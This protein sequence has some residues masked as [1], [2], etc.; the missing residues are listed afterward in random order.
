MKRTA[1]L[2]MIMLALAYPTLGQKKKVFPKLLEFAQYAYVETQ[3]GP[4]DETVLDSRVTNEDREA[5]ARVEKAIQTWGHY[6]LMAKP[7]EAD[8]ILVARPG[9]L[10]DG[11]VG[12]GTP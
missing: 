4:I 3:Y 5:V 2:A 12:V 9:R 6:K 11:N 1:V 7:S 8:V 10:V